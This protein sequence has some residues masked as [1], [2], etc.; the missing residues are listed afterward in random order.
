[1]V[2]AAGWL[3]LHYAAETGD[4]HSLGILLQASGG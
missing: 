1:M 4:E 2:D 3:P